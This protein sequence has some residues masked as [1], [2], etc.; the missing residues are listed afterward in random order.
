M[1][2]VT[3]GMREKGIKNTEWIDKKEWR[4]EIKLWAQEDAL[5]LILST[6]IKLL[7]YYK[8]NSNFGI[9]LKTR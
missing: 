3:T 1:Q 8:N 9:K 5:T 6:Q 7:I 4:R 2:E